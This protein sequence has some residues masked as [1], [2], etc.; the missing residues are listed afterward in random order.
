MPFT[1]G[2]VSYVILTDIQRLKFV[3]MYLSVTSQKCRG[4]LD[5]VKIDKAT[6]L[7]I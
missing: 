3:S 2:N 7:R 6:H 5:S 4:Q 1:Y